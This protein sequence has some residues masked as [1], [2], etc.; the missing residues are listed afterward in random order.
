[1]IRE[2]SENSDRSLNRV[3][4]GY[5]DFKVTCALFFFK[6]NFKSYLFW[7]NYD[8]LSKVTGAELEFYFLSF[9]YFQLF[10]YRIYK[11]LGM[12]KLQVPRKDLHLN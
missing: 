10:I 7:I 9:K 1:M 12:L 4:W 8:T 2:W 6:I 11:I 3:H 5:Y